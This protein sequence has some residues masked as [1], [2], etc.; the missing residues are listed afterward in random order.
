MGMSDGVNKVW[1]VRFRGGLE[2]EGFLSEHELAVALLSRGIDWTNPIRRLDEVQEVS[3]KA[4]ASIREQI[5]EEAR[6]EQEDFEDA[7]DEGPEVPDGQ[8]V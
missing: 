2:I 8:D 6:R 7:G 3:D 4:Q 5:A 1:L